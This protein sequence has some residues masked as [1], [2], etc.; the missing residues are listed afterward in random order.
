MGDSEKRA[1]V[2]RDPQEVAAPELVAALLRL[3]KGLPPAEG[4]GYV[5][6][7]KAVWEGV[8]G[9]PSVLVADAVQKN[10]VR[11]AMDAVWVGLLRKEDDADREPLAEGEAD[12]DPLAAGDVDAWDAVGDLQAELVAVIEF[13]KELEGVLERKIDG[14]DVDD[15]VGG[16][17]LK[18]DDTSG[19]AGM[20][21]AGTTEPNGVLDSG[22]TEASEVFEAAAEPAVV[23]VTA[24]EPAALL[25]TTA[26]PALLLEGAPDVVGVPGVENVTGFEY[27]TVLRGE[28]SMDTLPELL[29][30][31]RVE[32]GEPLRKTV[33]E[34][35]AGSDTEIHACGDRDGFNGEP[36]GVAEYDSAAVNALSTT[37]TLANTW[38]P[39]AYS[40]PPT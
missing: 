22:D 12:G 19:E 7:T 17:L 32:T 15:A 13:E 16:L 40:A 8:N 30:P 37:T 21:L 26:E 38:G 2:L 39:T 34:M 9:G 27:V 25:E 3:G 31:L 18:L 23:T 5:A 36:L 11:L 10:A 6:L 28:A 14:L 35:D 1:V 4:E 20:K 33:G 29:A 24:L